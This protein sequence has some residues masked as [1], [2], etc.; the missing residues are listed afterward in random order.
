M[1]V[2]VLVKIHVLA[3][4][5]IHVPTHVQI[6]VIQHVQINAATGVA[7]DVLLYVPEI[8]VQHVQTDA[9]LDAVHVHHV[10]E[11][12]L[13]VQGAF[14]AQAV[15][16]TVKTAVMTDVKGIVLQHAKGFVQH[17]AQA[18]VKIIAMKGAGHAHT[19]VPAVVMIA[20]KEIA[21]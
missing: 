5:Q 19:H 4:V 17:H 12:V 6:H 3:H 7:A 11:C 18:H 2:A 14:H 13:A 1:H 9:V 21:S 15:V 10:Q 20:V 8:A 16:R